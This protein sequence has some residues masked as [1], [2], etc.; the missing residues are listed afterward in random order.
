MP[1]TVYPV[2]HPIKYPIVLWP[3]PIDG[4]PCKGYSRL[5]TVAVHMHRWQAG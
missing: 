5:D 2:E 4:I 1:W 3:A